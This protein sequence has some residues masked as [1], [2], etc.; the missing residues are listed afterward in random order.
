VSSK[1]P[2]VQ[3][4]RGAALESAILDA[5]WDQLIEAGYERFTIDAVAARSGAARSVLYRRWPS[6]LELLRA[7]VRHRGEID[8]I[9]TPD[10]GTLRGDV[11][12]I[13]TEF[14]DR[15]S[16]T[17][18]L[19]AARL[20]AYFDEAGGSPQ[21]LRALFLADG[22]SSMETIVQ[23]AVARGELAAMP[24]ARIV[25]LPADLLRHE[26]LMTMTAASPQTILEIVDD[27][28]LPL[29]TNFGKGGRRD[30]PSDEPRATDSKP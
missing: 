27:V 29:A 6:R 8:A 9:P 21:Q 20:G 28:F 16:R 2:A 18:G 11:L 19:I 30:E 1:N 3:R 4:R 17:I 7:V 13:L 23:R 5:G 14:N 26:L 10:T 22:P 12:A 15:R 24:P 25:S